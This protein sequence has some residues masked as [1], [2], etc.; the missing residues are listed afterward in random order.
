METT[1]IF[2]FTGEKVNPIMEV[3][4]AVKLFSYQGVKNVEN[5]YNFKLIDI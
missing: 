3:N 2:V 1:G 4:R 5:A